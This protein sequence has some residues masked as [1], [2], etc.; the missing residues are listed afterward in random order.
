MA[1]WSLFFLFLP[2]IGIGQH[3]S[4]L[5]TELAIEG[6]I[7][8]QWRWGTEINTRF[9]ENGI[10]TF[11]P[12]VSLEYRV[13]KWFRPSLDYRFVSDKKIQGF[14]DYGQRINC[15]LNFRFP[16]ERFVFKAR[17]RYQYSFDRLVNN[18]FYEPE[19]DNAV[20]GKLGVEY[21]I[22]DFI[23]TPVVSG[24]L[25]YNPTYGP[26]GQQFN[27]LRIYAGLKT[28]LSGPHSFSIGYL[29][30]N[31]INLPNPRIRHILNIGYTY[32]IGKSE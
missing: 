2:F 1:R 20:R 12:Q 8:K 3:S 10:E 4:K 22:D 17:I 13:K 11:F 14:Y 16:V 27:K 26:Y 23:L 30:D 32:Q 15:N 24:E 21:D 7:S 18:A 9:G 19:F 5:W 29:F 6:R 25:F 31:R 28:D